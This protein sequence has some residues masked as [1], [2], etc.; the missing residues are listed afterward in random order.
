MIAEAD[1]TDMWRDDIR[2]LNDRFTKILGKPIQHAIPGERHAHVEQHPNLSKI[3]VC[4]QCI[5][6]HGPM[7]RSAEC[8]GVQAKPV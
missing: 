8:D 4:M 7:F 2:R 5:T 6:D 1:A 3:P